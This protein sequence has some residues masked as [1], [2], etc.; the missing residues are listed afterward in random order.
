MEICEFVWIIGALTKIILD[1]YPLPRVDELLDAIGN[2]KVVYLTTLDLMRRYHQ[3]KMAKESKEKTAFVCH[4]GLYQYCRMP[5]ELTN[6]PKVN[7]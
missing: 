3:V 5:F 1:R 2:Q 7:G 6:T 4:H